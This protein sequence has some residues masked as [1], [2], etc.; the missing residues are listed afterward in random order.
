MSH[1]KIM[2]FF[3]NEKGCELV[4]SPSWF[5]RNI[6]KP[7]YGLWYTFSYNGKKFDISIKKGK[8]RYEKYITEDWVDDCGVHWPANYPHRILFTTNSNSN[9]YEDA[10]KYVENL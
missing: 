9:W 5:E 10:W 1:N 8:V 3:V 4:S 7:Y 2:N 6:Y